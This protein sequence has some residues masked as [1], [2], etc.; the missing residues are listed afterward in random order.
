[1]AVSLVLLVGASLV[2][3][4]LANVHNVD[5]G[6]DVAR[7]AFVATGF[8]QGNASPEERAA[9][10]EE[11]MD[12]AATRPGVTA[13]AFTTRLPVQPGGSTTTVVEDYTPPAGTESVELPFALMSDDDFRTVGL[14]VTAGRAFGRQDALGTIPV[15][16]VNETAARR[17]WDNTNPVGRRV[18]PQGN[19]DGWVQ[20]VGVVEDSKVSSL[21][22]R[23]SPMVCYPV[24]QSPAS[25]YILVRTDG[26]PGALL[27]GTGT[28]GHGPHDR[29][30]IAGPSGPRNGA[31][32]S[33]LWARSVRPIGFSS[34]SSAWW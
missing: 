17:F 24:R 18:R 14:R 11:L 10:L 21:D 30:A 1:M 29:T 26:N 23:P 6:V 5:P 8:G 28:L 3:R 22:E 9:R 16:L 7:L 12:R 2:T 31:I 20:V 33:S 34:G 13:V 19:P 15:V 32:V 25:G 4:S 27:P